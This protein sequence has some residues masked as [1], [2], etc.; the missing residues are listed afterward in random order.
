MSWTWSAKFHV[1]SLGL[2]LWVQ[3]FESPGLTIRM[4]QAIYC[5]LCIMY[6]SSR[7]VRSGGLVSCRVSE[8]I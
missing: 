8:R 6:C 7:R 3:D 2:G 4:V 1:P 5:F